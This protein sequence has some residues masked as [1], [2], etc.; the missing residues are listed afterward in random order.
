[1]LLWVVLVF[2]PHW[3]LANRG[4]PQIILRIQSF[5]PVA[6]LVAV[7]VLDWNRL[8]IHKPLLAYGA[9]VILY[10]PYAYNQLGAEPHAKEMV[11]AITLAVATL[12]LVR[13][14]RQVRQ[15]VLMMLLYRF[16]WY[17]FLGVW[18]G[19]VRY[20]PYLN[21]EDA[22]GALMAM[23]VV[24]A[25]SVGLAATD[26]RLRWFAA[27]VTL[28]CV[29]GL[30]SSFAR[31]AF[32]VGALS[33]AF[34]WVRAEGRRLAYAALVV[35]TAVTTLV[36]GNAFTD[37]S[38]GRQDGL[39]FWRELSSVTDDI[40]DTDAEDRRLVWRIGWQVYK[41]HPAVGV[42][43]G[44]WSAYASD[45][46]RGPIL[47]E[48]FGRDPE[49]LWGR[50]MHNIYIERLAE[51]GTVGFGLFLLVLVDYWRRILTVRRNTPKSD[52]SVLPGLRTT[53][54]A[55][56][57]EV[58]MVALLASGIFYNSVRI[59]F[60]ALV[61]ANALFHGA[62]M[63]QRLATPPHRASAAPAPAQLIRR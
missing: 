39:S 3:F 24:A 7:L 49:T 38:R 40:V 47:G 25:A 53:M 56:S 57:F 28:L 45:N 12:T 15:I 11:V 21:N 1:L 8:K 41:D 48:R 6:M 13:H 62:W 60:Y 10:T 4:A 42:G 5:L 14:A 43:P 63:R 18:F 50:A 31:G 34:L 51:L 26:R 27:S 61:V 58:S 20:D 29:A 54:I 30:I 59:S 36:V 19:V 35:L 46:Y 52:T 2:N 22:F 44:G 37:V 33:V 9:F 55:T 17:G 23:G 16:A 32:L